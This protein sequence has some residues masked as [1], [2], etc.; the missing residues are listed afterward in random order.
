M[1]MERPQGPNELTYEIMAN[2]TREE[3]RHRSY[4]AYPPSSF[5]HPCDVHPWDERIR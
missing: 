4:D 1:P 5:G 2:R 3:E